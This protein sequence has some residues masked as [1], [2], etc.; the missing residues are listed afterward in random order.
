MLSRISKNTLGPIFA[1]QKK[2]SLITKPVDHKSLNIKFLKIGTL[3]LNSKY[4]KTIEMINDGCTITIANTNSNADFARDIDILHHFCFNEE[5]V[6][7]QQKW[8][9]TYTL[10]SNL[11]KENIQKFLD[12][13]T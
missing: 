7:P 13:N 11:D 2:R 9:D 8:Y 10:I 1:K 4:I 5:S 3:Y 6:K 12:S